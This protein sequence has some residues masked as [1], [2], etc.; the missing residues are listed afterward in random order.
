MIIMNSSKD[1]DRYPVW[2]QVAVCLFGCSLYF[3]SFT[4]I[5]GQLLIIPEVMRQLG[6]GVFVFGI[7]SF[8]LTHWY[9]R[10]S[11]R[12]L[13]KIGEEIKLLTTDTFDLV[14][15]ARDSGIARIYPL[16]T[17]E[18][19]ENRD[20]ERAFKDR[21][22]MEFAKA[23]QL[24]LESKES[25]TIRMMG[26][27]LRAFFNDSGDLFAMAENALRNKL[28]SF[29][30]LLVDPLSAQAG[31]RSERESQTHEDQEY[32][33]VEEHFTSTLFTDLQKCTR[34]LNRFTETGGRVDVRLYSTAPSCFLVFI[35]ESVFVE[36][37]HYGRSGIGGLKGGKVPVLE[38]HSDTST[39]KELEGHFDH[40][41]FKS[42]NRKLDQALTG[43]INGSRTDLLI[44]KLRQEFFWITER[45]PM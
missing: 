33:N 3:V 20:A 35:N 40:V 10:L 6:I 9:A 41:W 5:V 13:E 21:L 44:N 19:A 39:Y 15:S 31:L 2:V 26:I 29:K 16:R 14:K 30:I 17:G 1:I 18:L 27:S 11:S 23:E 4:P 32:N 37:Y 28:L 12:Q 36:T 22:R 8:A 24:A 45:K 42:R 38:F 7:T 43:E 34:T 25:K